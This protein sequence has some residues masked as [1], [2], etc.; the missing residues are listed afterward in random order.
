M[1][2]VLYGLAAICIVV[3][4]VFKK[5]SLEKP[6][7]K[8]MMIVALG[9]GFLCGALGAVMPM[10]TNT[11]END[12]SANKFM[13]CG[14]GVAKALEA[15]GAKI[16]LIRSSNTLR[17]EDF[18][19]GLK[20][21]AGADNVQEFLAKD[22]NPK[23]KRTFDK[24]SFDLFVKNNPDYKKVIFYSLPV[25]ANIIKSKALKRK[26]M[27]LCLDHLG[28]FLKKLVLNL[29]F[30]SLNQLKKI[31]LKRRLLLK[32]NRKHLKISLLI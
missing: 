9:A 17:L 20:E 23:M 18:M 25:D 26:I 22:I 12:I 15:K 21:V 29:L 8:N 31:K 6:Q 30:V 11:S 2:F 16:A 24:K 10:L 7:M 4:L 27:S 32:M 28:L 1:M 5:Q 14:K 13:L 3:A 19:K